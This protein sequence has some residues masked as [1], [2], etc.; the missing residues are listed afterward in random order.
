MSASVTSATSAATTSGSSSFQCRAIVETKV[1]TTSTSASISAAI[2]RGSGSIRSAAEAAAAAES[3]ES[4][5]DNND[6]TGTTDKFLLLVD[7]LSL[8]QPNHLSIKDIGIILDRLSSKIVDVAMLE[9]QVEAT[10]T[11]NWTIKA[12]IRGEV[13]RELGVIYNSNYYAISEH[14]SFSFVKELASA[15]AAGVTSSGHPGGDHALP[16]EDVG[17]DEDFDDVEAD[18]PVDHRGIQ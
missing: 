11:H 13:M 7:Q 14:P 4:E 6:E 17:L 2:G 12:T 9:R 15:A 1:T 3:S 16:L 5:T 18:D 8:E 10:D